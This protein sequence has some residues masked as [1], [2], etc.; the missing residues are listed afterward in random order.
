MKLEK[1]IEIKAPRAKV[2]AALAAVQNWPLWTESVTRIE[3]LDDGPFGVGSQVRITQPKLP[4]LVWQVVE[5]E[6]G[7]SFAWRATSRGVTT[8]ASHR[9]AE[10]AAGQ[11][12]VTLAIKQTGPL[13]SL[14]GLA[15]GWVTRRYV[16]MEAE[17][18][19]RFCESGT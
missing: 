8:L 13:A 2:W 19:K 3:R 15:L 7:A 14:A 9:V 11:S 17:G 6:P 12:T 1:T 5:F 18:L 4:V 16:D 10:A